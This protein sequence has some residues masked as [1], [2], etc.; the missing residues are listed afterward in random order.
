MRPSIRQDYVH[1]ATDEFQRRE[2]PR[3]ALVT[4]ADLAPLPAPV[5]RYLRVAGAV[6]KP[7]V[8]NMRVELDA[9]MTSKPGD[10]PMRA[11]SEQYNFFDDPTRLFYMNAWMFGLPV[12]VLHRYTR[13][14]ATMVVRVAGLYN[15]VNASGPELD[16]TET[17]TVLNDMALFAP[18][19]LI[20]PR[21]EWRAIDAA[22]C[23]VTF[24]NGP[25]AVRAVLH[26]AAN[27][28]LS[29]FVS[30]DRS[31]LGADGVFRKQ[32]FSTPVRAYRDFGEGLRLASAGKA[33]YD[34]P[35]GPFEYASV[36]VRSVRYN[37]PCFDPPHFGAIRALRRSEA[38]SQLHT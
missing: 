32:R 16:T 15:V 3:E 5:Q 7:R 19:S 27:G 30:D 26:F 38:A 24:H 29:T 12:S 9:A 34:T 10:S 17:V 13:Q 37:V 36:V 4:P 25:Q 18:A 31:A 21:L 28:E 8:R 33:I 20:D 1:Y 14:H 22:S 2:A 35:E 23:E 11:I 6:G